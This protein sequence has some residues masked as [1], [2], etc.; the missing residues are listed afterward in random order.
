MPVSPVNQA[1]NEEQAECLRLFNTQ[2]FNRLQ[3][4]NAAE[5]EAR[6]R[7][8][9][10]TGE[11]ADDGAIGVTDLNA[12]FWK[13]LD[14]TDVGFH[15]FL[16]LVKVVANVIANH[17][18]SDQENPQTSCYKGMSK[19]PVAWSLAMLSFVPLAVGIVLSILN[20]H[21]A[22]KRLGMDHLLE[23]LNRVM[24]GNPV[25]IEE[26]L[27]AGQH[28]LDKSAVQF[29]PTPAPVA[30]KKSN[31]QKALSMADRVWNVLNRTS[32]VFWPAWM[33]AVLVVGIGAAGGP[34][35]LGIVVGAAIAVSIAIHVSVYLAKRHAKKK[36]AQARNE[37]A[38]TKEAVKQLKQD[39]ENLRQ[40]QA[41]LGQQLFIRQK[42]QYVM[43]L[44]RPLEAKVAKRVNR[45][46]KSLLFLDEKSKR[47]YLIPGAA[48][49]NEGKAVTEDDKQKARDSKIAQQFL[50]GSASARRASIAI[51]AI[52]EAINQYTAA[53]FIL[54]LVGS[55]LSV[56]A[57][58]AAAIGAVATVVL[59]GILGA[60]FGGFIGALSSL[61][62]VVNAK[63]AQ[64]AFDEAVLVKLS[65]PYHSAKEKD[66]L[67]NGKPKHEVFDKLFKANQGYRQIKG[68]G[69][70]FDLLKQ[71]QK[72][73]LNK[74]KADRT[75]QDKYLLTL[76]LTQNS[77]M[78]DRFFRT[79]EE[80]PSAFTS[81]KKVAQRVYSAVNAGQTWIFVARSLFLAGSVAGGMSLFFGPFA[82]LAFLVIATTMAAVG[83]GLRLASL[84]YNRKQESKRYFVETL[85]ARI[86][87]LKKQNKQF[88][89]IRQTLMNGSG[90]EQHRSPVYR[91]D[92]PEQGKQASVQDEIHVE[93]QS[94]SVN[95]KV[96]PSRL[97]YPSGLFDHPKELPAGSNIGG[98]RR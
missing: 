12:A 36:A 47:P 66:A 52:N 48:A 22:S 71:K 69:T 10:K 56:F 38:P 4:Q 27:R 58:A 3:Q 16:R 39:T 54:W 33:I 51:N 46:N 17:S 78:N 18:N 86:V 90:N 13:G 35:V 89:E 94:V 26:V 68:D 29:H 11:P 14:V 85:D 96:L 81:V 9:Q 50:I 57:P 79:L 40:M 44:F 97:G 80:S 62:W 75:P 1:H 59:G 25:T 64:A 84:H 6:R 74:K 28:L 83:I 23:Q 93:A 63:K 55:A 72:E 31:A 65:A 95:E 53:S 32:M 82:L 88:Y 2:Q 41:E 42:H 15:T 49:A 87:F 5:Y 61:R 67:L 77:V 70:L 30:E 34:F 21:K 73:I 37:I 24:P 45:E 8:L 76:D 43:G 19:P 92:D 60:S 98:L 20:Q 7:A 91:R